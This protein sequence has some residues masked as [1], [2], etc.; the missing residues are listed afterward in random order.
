M[1]TIAIGKVLNMSYD[2]VRALPREVYDVVLE[3]LH[4]RHAAQEALV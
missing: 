4:A 3:D 1:T 2:A